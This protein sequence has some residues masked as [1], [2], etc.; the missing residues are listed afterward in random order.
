M[1]DEN[2]VGAR[3]AEIC[4]KPEQSGQPVMASPAA[5]H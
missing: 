4:G 2:G 1:N 3:P 5:A